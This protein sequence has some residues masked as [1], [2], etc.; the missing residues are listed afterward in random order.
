MAGKLTLDGV[1]VRNW[2]QAAVVVAGGTVVLRNGTVLDKIGKAG[3]ACDTGSA[4]LVSAQLTIDHST[5]SNARGA[6]ICVLNSFSP[7]VAVPLVLTQ[8]TITGSAGA[9]I[10]NFSTQGVGPTITADG[11]SLTNNGW[12]IFWNR[13]GSIDLRNSTIS[14]ST[15]LAFG[16]GLYLN[17]PSGSFKLRG[18]SVTGNVQYGVL[19][20]G[21]QSAG[22]P[23]ADLGTAADPGGNTFTGNG[24][25]GLRSVAA[26]GQSVDAVGNTW[27]PNQQGAD[28]N[29]RYSLPPTFTPVP[30]TGPASGVNFK[31]DNATAL[32]L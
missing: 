4:V 12:G 22:G 30:N 13:D 32:N 10:Q 28:A 26:T 7:T 6:A 27:I 18:S 1:I 17:M 29:G 8:S 20:D 16:A 11:A 9:A 2:P 3:V 31:I 15:S 5:L 23:T 14:G 25:A 21:T 24:L 19:I